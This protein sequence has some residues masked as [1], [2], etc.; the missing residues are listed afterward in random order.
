MGSAKRLENQ[1][2]GSVVGSDQAQGQHGTKGTG[3]AGPPPQ[4]RLKT[5]Q[6][7]TS[8]VPTATRPFQELEF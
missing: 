4:S 6:E 3:K 2:L 5:P 1:S 7:G 8:A